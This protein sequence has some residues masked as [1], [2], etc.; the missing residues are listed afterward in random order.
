MYPGLPV[1][2]PILH[3]NSS[4]EKPSSGGKCANN[5]DDEEPIM[6]GEPV[7]MMPSVMPPSHGGVGDQDMYNYEFNPQDMPNSSERDFNTAQQ[8]LH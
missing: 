7:L 8:E 4:H 5:G 6:H 1:D 3:S 2:D